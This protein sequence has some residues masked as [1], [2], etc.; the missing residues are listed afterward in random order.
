[1]AAPAAPAFSYT[2][3]AVVST[4]GFAESFLHGLLQAK[5]YTT[6]RAVTRKPLETDHVKTKRIELLRSL[7]AQICYYN[8]ESVEAFTQ[9]F[10]DIEVVLSA[11]S[12]PAVASQIPM[13]DGA[14]AAGVKWFLPSAFGVTHYISRHL[15]IE[16]PL[17]AMV[18][19]QKYLEQVRERGMASTIVYTGLSMDFLDPRSIGLNVHKRSAT[20]VGRGGSRVSFTTLADTQK[21]VLSILDRPAEMQNRVIRYAG[22]TCN[23]RELVKLVTGNDRGENVRMLSICEAKNKL[24]EMAMKKDNMAFF[25]YCRILIEEGLAQIDR[26]PDEHLDNDLFPD[27]HPQHIFDTLKLLIARAEASKSSASEP[28]GISA[29][30]SSAEDSSA[31]PAAATA[32]PV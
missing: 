2:S 22:S 1:M 23:M 32:Q 20:L 24:C 17:D 28:N 19:V 11:V 12:V 21:L 18:P 25:M 16:G 10:Q 8:E 15:P 9:A 6:I 30:N 14:L 7:G 3:I 27:I 4:G 26:N 5:H 31:A 29:S 13:I